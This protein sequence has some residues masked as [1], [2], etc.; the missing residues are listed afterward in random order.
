MRNALLI[1][2]T[3]FV[4][5]GT[6]VTMSHV[7]TTPAVPKMVRHTIF[8]SLD[9][10]NEYVGDCYKGGFII[11]SISIVAQGQYTVDV[12]VLVVAEKY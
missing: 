1:V 8:N 6:T 12:R 9:A 5:M 10:A 3:A 11:K 4:L 7:I 2:L